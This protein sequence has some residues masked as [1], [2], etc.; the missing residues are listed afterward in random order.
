VRRR[1]QQSA[2]VLALPAASCE[3]FRLR[4]PAGLT[5]PEKALFVEL[6]A[7]CSPRHF[8]QSDVPLLVSYCQATLMSRRTVRDAS[9]VHIWEKATR[10][11][12]MLATRLRLAPQARTDPK[13]LARAQSGR[14]PSYYDLIR[15]V[16]DVDAGP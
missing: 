14:A 5:K 4:L 10:M 3:P 2:D 13:T 8:V 16:E 11:Q 6:V 7:S 12:A 9:K 1:G 15:G